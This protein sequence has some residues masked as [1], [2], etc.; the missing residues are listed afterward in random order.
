MKYRHKLN[1]SQ[2]IPPIIVMGG[3]YKGGNAM[4]NT[5]K[6][7]DIIYIDLALDYINSI[8]NVRQYRLAQQVAMGVLTNDMIYSIYM[9]YSITNN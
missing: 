1:T 8:M 2:S 3:H 7:D 4:T 6:H 9:G 5:I